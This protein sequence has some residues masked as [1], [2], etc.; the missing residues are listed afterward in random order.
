MGSYSIGAQNTGCYPANVSS[1]VPSS[2]GVSLSCGSG[3]A[4]P[5][6]I[7]DL[8]GASIANP[9]TVASVTVDLRGMQK[10][11]V[12][13]LFT[14]LISVPLGALANI[15]FRIVRSCNGATQAIGGSYGY[16]SAVD[17]LHS[18][19]FTFQ[20]CD[21]GVCCDCATYSIEISNATLV[22]AG[23]TISGTVSAIAVDNGSGCCG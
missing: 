6:P 10:P 21:C 8:A 19:A 23:T 15:S 7:M 13:I 9:Y 4:G 1:N 14:G 20:T 17:A 16:S 22:Q 2:P 11:S 12:L 3:V 5:L 18:E